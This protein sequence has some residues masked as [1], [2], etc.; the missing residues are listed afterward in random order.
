MKN[1]KAAITTILAIGA[2][3]IIG[4]AGIFSALTVNNKQ[5]TSSRAATPLD[6]GTSATKLSHSS[7]AI[8][9][10]NSVCPANQPYTGVYQVYSNGGRDCCCKNAASNGTGGTGGGSSGG[11]TPQCNSTTSTQS[12][13]TCV[14]ACS[15]VAGG[16]TPLEYYCTAPPP[17]GLTPPTCSGKLGYSPAGTASNCSTICAPLG[18]YA[19]GQAVDS[20][21]RICCC[22]G[23]PAG[24]PP[25]VNGKY[26][27]CKVSPGVGGCGA[28]QA[29]VTWGG[30]YDST[31]PANGLTYCSDY[32]GLSQT[33]SGGC[34]ATTG[35]G[36]PAGVSNCA[37]SN[38]PKT[39]NV[40]YYC[41]TN[42]LGKN[43]NQYY[44]SNSLYYQKDTSSCSMIDISS[45]CGCPTSAVPPV[46]T[47]CETAL[48]TSDCKASH[49]TWSFTAPNSCC[50][51]STA[52]P[53]PAGNPP[54]CIPA[55]NGSCSNNNTFSTYKNNITGYSGNWCCRPDKTSTPQVVDLLLN[56][57]LTKVERIKKY[58]ATWNTA[59]ILCMNGFSEY[60]SNIKY[61]CP[62]DYLTRTD[63][64]I[65]SPP[66]QSNNESNST[67]GQDIPPA[68][69]GT[70]KPVTCSS[71][72]ASFGGLVSGFRQSETNFNNRNGLWYGK[73]DTGCNVDIDATNVLAYCGCTTPPRDP[74]PKA[75]SGKTNQTGTLIEYY[76]CSIQF[77]CTQ[78]R[79]E[80]NLICGRL[81]GRSSPDTAWGLCYSNC[82]NF[83]YMNVTTVKSFLYCCDDRRSRL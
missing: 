63:A 71:A 72:C 77:D 21:S 68:N 54:N 29:W 79:T 60:I 49:Q 38:G 32:N 82:A 23:V 52:N 64:G 30:R 39:C 50:P 61:C 75:V 16:A 55:I 9:S 74:L 43:S 44:V 36:A 25:P 35:V 15:V 26:E 58:C 56:T 80:D 2:L 10:C 70:C 31:C 51:P 67:T 62:T 13:K 73:S 12:G 59:Y 57:N 37:S 20:T 47:N 81:Y 45:Y 48:N 41:D 28:G 6:C 33:N 5:S 76:N 3:V 22:K 17:S 8:A 40:N 53:P 19:G 18:G 65:N 24:Q 14:T 4:I 27:C 42:V 11:S 7:S 1:R 34:F 69:D 46:G 83:C 78:N 66:V